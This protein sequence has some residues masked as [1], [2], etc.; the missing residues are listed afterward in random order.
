LKVEDVD[1]LRHK[2]GLA[3]PV[4]GIEPRVRDYRRRGHENPKTVVPAHAQRSALLNLVNCCKQA[5]TSTTA[6]SPPVLES[7]SVIAILHQLTKRDSTYGSLPALRYCA[8]GF[9]D[10]LD[11]SCF[12]VSLSQRCGGP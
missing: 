7:M 6:G 1:A 8:L 5:I 9:I 3:W 2:S 11:V 12:Q 4:A 10:P